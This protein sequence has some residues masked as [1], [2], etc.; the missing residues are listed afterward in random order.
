MI[1]VGLDWSRSKH[2]FVI[3][4]LQ[5]KVIER[6]TIAHKTNALEE[7]ATRIEHHVDAEEIAYSV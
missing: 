3:M 6:G 7:L 1:I 4:D 2:D 5:G